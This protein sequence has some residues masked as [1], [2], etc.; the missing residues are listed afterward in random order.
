MT[1]SALLTEICGKRYVNGSFLEDDAL[2]SLS[3][4]S[5][6]NTFAI[7]PWTYS[8]HFLYI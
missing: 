1:D 5:I 8:R 3:N 6:A 2:S 7:F 4:G